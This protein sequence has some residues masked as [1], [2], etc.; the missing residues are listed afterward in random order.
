MLRDR[1]PGDRFFARILTLE[2]ECPACGQVYS[3][4]GLN[5]KRR[6]GKPP[7]RSKQEG[8]NSRIGRFCCSSCQTVFLLGVVA[9]RPKPSGIRNAIPEDWQPT[10]RQA[11]AL[12]GE[13][14]SVV[15]YEPRVY[16]ADARNIVI[17]QPCSCID[18]ADGGR[19]THP[20]CPVHGH[21]GIAVQR[22]QQI[23]EEAEHR[24]KERIRL[25]ENMRHR[26][27]RAKKR[28]AQMV[29]LQQKDARGRYVPMP[30]GVPEPDPDPSLTPGVPG[31]EGYTGNEYERE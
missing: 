24:R 4:T 31:A 11:L 26:A 27:Q 18:T 1:L 23:A 14:P 8:W 28:A 16:A 22:Q 12:A 17:T 13:I 2:L 6:H 3:H 29:R 30:D 21:A 9:Y 5:P 7:A 10:L 19:W 25:W 20:A 15:Q